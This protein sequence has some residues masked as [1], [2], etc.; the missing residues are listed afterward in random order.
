MAAIFVISGSGTGNGRAWPGHQ[1]AL[2][3]SMGIQLHKLVH[4]RQQ[5]NERTAQEGTRG[6]W[7]V[8]RELRGLTT[9]GPAVR[10]KW[11]AVGFPKITSLA[12]FWKSEFRRFHIWI[13]M[14]QSPSRKIQVRICSKHGDFRRKILASNSRKW[15]C[16][17]PASKCSTTKISLNR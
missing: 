1:S 8:Q 4:C 7:T 2:Q 13:I 3:T 6:L 10:F 5:G 9:T 14:D 12:S 11:T 16:H 17:D 15:P